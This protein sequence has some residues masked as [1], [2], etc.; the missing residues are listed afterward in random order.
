LKIVSCIW[1]MSR[2]LNVF[3]AILSIWIAAL[4][5]GMIT[6][7]FR[8]IIASLIAAFITAGANF[9]ND[10]YDIEIDRVNKPGRCLPSGQI[11]IKSAL[12]VFLIFYCS[13]FIMAAYAGL[14]MF[15]ITLLVG[16]LLIF[17]SYK[18]KRTIL[19]G[20]AV[21]S[22]STATAFIF[23]AM[24]VGNWHAGI[25]PAIFAF[26]FHFGREIVKDMQDIKGDLAQNA[27]T[28]PGKY[29]FKKSVI[30]INILF[31]CLILL[32]FIPYI[33][34]MYNKWYLITVVIGVDLV[35]VFVSISLWI[36][37]DTSALGKL[38]HLLK[39]DMMIGIFAIYI[40]I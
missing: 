18:L 22:L 28:F 31:I 23:G 30:L 39:L 26:F 19:L 21:V 20:N 40:G 12:S 33:L 36:W 7:S 5:T 17:Y 14:G 38:S 8:I 6:F 13:A 11:S 1:K 29:G 9:I 2:P 10:I 34:S 27:V 4:V 25:I 37:Q 16:I 35:L 15:I 32:T 24:A 3:I